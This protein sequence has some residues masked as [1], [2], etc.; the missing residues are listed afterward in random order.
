MTKKSLI[1]GAVG[2]FLL[3]LSGGCG[4]GPEPGPDK[5]EIRKGADEGMRDL[6]MEEE[7]RN[8]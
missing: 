7:R 2:I 6:R 5:N 8:R 1:P 3:L 4:G